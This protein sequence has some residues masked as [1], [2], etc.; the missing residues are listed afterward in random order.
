M[1]D[2]VVVVEA[3]DEVGAGDVALGDEG[4]GNGVAVAGVEVMLEVGGGGGGGRGEAVVV[5]DADV[6]VGGQEG[7]GDEGG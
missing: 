3:H 4:V 6:E 7:A 2:G 5:F 1:L